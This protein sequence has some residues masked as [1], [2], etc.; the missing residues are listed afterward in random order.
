MKLRYNGPPDMVNQAVGEQNPDKGALLQPGHTY[1]VAGDAAKE[2]LKT[3]LWSRVQE[4]SA[5]DDKE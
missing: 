5:K 3:E 2:L 1:E 4:S